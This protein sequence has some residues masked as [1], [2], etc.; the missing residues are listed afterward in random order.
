MPIDLD[1]LEVLYISGKF[2]LGSIPDTVLGLIA[3]L[4]KAKAAQEWIV[5]RVVANNDAC[6]HPCKCNGC[7][8]SE[9]ECVKCW[10]NAAKEATCPKN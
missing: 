8:P 1:A 6:V 4:R 10:L 3:E 9:E 2:T 7:P 5:Q